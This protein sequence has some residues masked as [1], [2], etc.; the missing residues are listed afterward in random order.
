MLDE[1]EEDI[2][3]VTLDRDDVNESNIT[4]NRLQIWSSMFMISGDNRIVG[5]SPRNVLAYAKV[6]YPDSF[7]VKKNYECHNGYLA[8]LASTGI[9]G[10][11]V[12]TDKRN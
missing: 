11:I 9:V 1:S 4:N 8:V 10:T 2:K 5:L 12:L 7:V 6:N 3:E